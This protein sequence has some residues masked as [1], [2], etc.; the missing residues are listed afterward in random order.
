MSGS[1]PSSPSPTRAVSPGRAPVV[2]AP[3]DNNVGEILLH[4]HEEGRPASPERPASP[5]MTFA[6]GMT[7]EVEGGEPLKGSLLMGPDYTMP[8]APCSTSNQEAQAGGPTL[9]TRVLPMIREYSQ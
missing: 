8:C 9:N 5:S 6:A 3:R 7:A 4:D 2:G 1:P